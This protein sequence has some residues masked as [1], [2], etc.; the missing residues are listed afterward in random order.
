[1]K[2]LL[3]LALLALARLCAAQTVVTPIVSPHITF[4]DNSG[5]PCALCK[6]YTYTGGTTTPK[7]TYTDSTGTSQNTNPI[8]LDVS[9]STNIWVASGSAYKFI[10]KDTL[11]TTLWSVDNVKA[12]FTVDAGSLTGILGSAHGGTGIDSSTSTGCPQITAGVWTVSPDNCSAGS[13]VQKNPTGNQVITAPIGTSLFTNISGSSLF[14][15]QLINMFGDSITN[16]T[17]CTVMANCYASKI[18]NAFGGGNNY[19]VSGTWAENQVAVMYAQL[20]PMHADNSWSSLMVGTNNASFCGASAGCLANYLH[21]VLSGVAWSAIPLEYKMEAQT[22]ACTTTGSWTNATFGNAFGK[23]SIV[24][25]STITCTSLT[26]GATGIYVNWEAFVSGNTSAATVSIDGNP[27]PDALSGAGY[28]GV[29][30]NANT[31]F[32]SRYA[33]SGTGVHSVTITVTSASSGSPFVFLWAGSPSPVPSTNMANITANP[34]RTALMGVLWQGAN[35]I[36]DTTLAY[37]NDDQQIS[38]W[39]TGDGAI[40]PFVPTRAY[41]NYTTDFLTS[42]AILPN[43]QICPASVDP[44]PP[45]VHPNDCG[46]QH[47]ADVF[48]QTIGTPSGPSGTNTSVPYVFVHALGGLGTDV[49]EFAYDPSVH[50]AIVDGFGVDGSTNGAVTIG[51][52]TSSGL[53][54]RTVVVNGQGISFLFGASTKFLQELTRATFA[55]LLAVQGTGTAPA[56][57]T[58][59]SYDTGGNTGTVQSVGPDNATLAPLVMSASSL[60]GSVRKNL[61]LN[62]TSLISDVPFGAP[63]VTPG[64]GFSGTKTAGSCVLTIDHGIITNVTGC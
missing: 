2:R 51:S 36:P 53:N 55:T 17:G 32:G 44:G 12:T 6:L 26:A 62:N 9:G 27:Q 64:N 10:L 42:P 23:Q 52:Y 49:G 1:M 58:T 7:P 25:G 11:G 38:Q 40:V 28:S 35:A 41:V 37:Y 5:A 57:T 34:P 3:A 61:T 63:T 31:A 59:L 30:V 60:N 16:Y 20:N 22:P 15:K 13:S 45:L 4:V 33:V 24:P 19:A 54:G 43:G 14:S 29:P 39:L 46:H 48:L 50:A 47:I 18:L 8:T 21:S 56:Q